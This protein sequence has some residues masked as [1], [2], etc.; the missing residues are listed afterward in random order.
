MV[1]VILGIVLVMFFSN[2]GF[3]QTVIPAKSGVTYSTIGNITTGS[4][5]TFYSTIVFD[6]SCY[7]TFYDLFQLNLI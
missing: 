7:R 3:A 5:G 4:D 1:K 2:I 6:N